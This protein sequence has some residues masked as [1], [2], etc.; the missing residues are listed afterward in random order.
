MEQRTFTLD[1]NV[2]GDER[3]R[4]V[5]AVSAFAQAEAKYLGVPSCAY[6]V[7]G[8]TIDKTGRVSTG[9]REAVNTLIAALAAEGFEAQAFDLGEDTGAPAE[10]ATEFGAT[11]TDGLTISLPLDGFNPDSLDRLQKLV[12]SKA[13]LIQKALGADRLTIQAS[14]GTVRFPW[15]SRMPSPDETQAYTAFIAA[16]CKMAKEAKR[17]TATEKEVESEKYAFRGFL[18]RLGFIG[19]ACKAQRKTLLK[20][21]SG[22]SAFPSKAAADAFSAAQKAKRDAAKAAKEVEA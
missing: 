18:L 5:K 6:R 21:L 14:D 9:E 16:I 15:W 11:D 8:F 3:K 17:V 22:A 1:F 4:L 7:G 20:N 19:N 12:D 10:E 13:K 2:T